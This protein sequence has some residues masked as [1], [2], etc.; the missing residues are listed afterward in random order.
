MKQI[1]A[2]IYILAFCSI[3][4]RA[5][6]NQDPR[7]FPFQKGTVW[8]Y[9]G[10]F[11]NTKNQ[12][13]DKIVSRWEMK[14]LDIQQQG[15]MEVALVSGFPGTYD[16]ETKEPE[17]ARAL[18]IRNKEGNYY[19]ISATAHPKDSLNAIPAAAIIRMRLT[20]DNLIWVRKPRVGELFGQGPHYDRND[21]MYCWK[22]MGWRPF[23]LSKVIKT[24]PVRSARKYIL[25]YY[26][27]ADHVIIDYVE[28][29]GIVS[30]V[31]MHHATVRQTYIKLMQIRVENGG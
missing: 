27:N 5:V 1:L 28:G 23:D 2:S 26:T 16:P 18:V 14:V 8:A 20:E 15:D 17:T 3:V 6:V 9:E 4:I 21:G 30:Y 29:I 24:P 22:V 12:R 7:L 11:F 19:L 31:Y 25:G 13:V 10:T